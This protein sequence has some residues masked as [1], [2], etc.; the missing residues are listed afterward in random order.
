M[1]YRIAQPCRYITIRHY[2]RKQRARLPVA[3]VLTV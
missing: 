3:G 2:A 1:W